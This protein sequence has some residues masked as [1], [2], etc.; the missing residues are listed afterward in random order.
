MRITGDG[1]DF[2]TNVNAL[3]YGD[4]NAVNPSDSV[5]NSFN[6]V[7][8]SKMMMQ[9]FGLVYTSD[10]KEAAMV[11]YTTIDDISF[12]KRTFRVEG[13]VVMMALD[14]DSFLYTVYWCSNRKLE[15]KIRFDVLDNALQELSLC[16]PAKWDEYAVLVY[17]ASVTCR[18]AS[19]TYS[20]PLVRAD[21]Q[22]VVKSRADSWF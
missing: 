13:G 10:R 17:N 19:S 18:D 6:Q 22:R 7:S 5:K 16:E 9:E 4:D 21:Y 1:K 15:R 8:V 2:W 11:P 12:L 20:A 3:T 14:L